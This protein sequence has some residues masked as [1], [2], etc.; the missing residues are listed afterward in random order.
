MQSINS[1]RIMYLH[2]PDSISILNTQHAFFSPSKNSFLQH[3]IWVSFGLANI[4]R[5]WLMLNQLYPSHAYRYVGAL[6]FTIF[7]PS[8][9]TLLN[10]EN[11]VV[12]GGVIYSKHKVVTVCVISIVRRKHD[13]VLL[14]SRHAFVYGVWCVQQVLF[15]ARAWYAL[16]L[17][18][19]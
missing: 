19:Q 1:D 11:N 13:V 14:S 12:V 18:R 15:G 16:H 3:G 4:Y 2:N 8:F 6:F 10:E 5:L 17:P 7:I 9:D